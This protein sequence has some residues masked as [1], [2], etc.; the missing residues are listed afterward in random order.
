MKKWITLIFLASG[1][2]VR[3]IADSGT[4]PPKSVG[5]VDV[6]IQGAG[7]PLQITG[8]AGVRNVAAQ[9]SVFERE[10]IHTQSNQSA[11]I[12]LLEGTVLI[13]G[14][15]TELSLD[16]VSHSSETPIVVSLPS[17]SMYSE[18]PPVASKNEMRF[19]VRC[20]S[21]VMGVRGTVFVAENL[22]DGTST[23]HTLDGSVG[24]AKTPEE[25]SKP[26]GFHTVGSGEMASAPEKGPV[27]SPRKFNRKTYLQE[28]SRRSPQFHRHVVH[29]IKVRRARRRAE[30]RSDPQ[31]Q[32]EVEKRRQKHKRARGRQ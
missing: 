11:T 12:H 9:D 2:I 8:P 23:L 3:V 22:L 25:L 4:P 6:E 20:R 14:P 26:G 31:H 5:Q 29:Q 10:V 18:V 1:L 24:I 28:L 16:A 7:A 13:L 32:D 19:K 27:T 17:G 15:S 21:A 30:L